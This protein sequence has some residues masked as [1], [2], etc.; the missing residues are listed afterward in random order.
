MAWSRTGA[1]KRLVDFQSA[2]LGRSWERDE[3]YMIGLRGNHSSIVKLPQYRNDSYDKIYDVLSTLLAVASRVINARF[4]LLLKDL[5]RH[6]SR[7]LLRS[8]R[9]LGAPLSEGLDSRSDEDAARQEIQV[10]QDR[11]GTQKYLTGI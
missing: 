4:E 9:S 7:N 10:Q 2:T 11:R 6:A 5:G 3:E 1:L 8:E